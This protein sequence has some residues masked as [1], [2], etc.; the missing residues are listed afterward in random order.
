M[1][2]QSAKKNEQAIKNRV[3]FMNFIM[4]PLFAF[5]LL[6][7]MFF[8]IGE[9]I[10]F[11]HLIWCALISV[12]SFFCIKQTVKCWELNLPVEASEYYI[13]ILALNTIVAVLDPF[14]HKVW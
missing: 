11:W 14:T 6:L 2:N 1:A 3:K 13:D 10:S 4:Y 12:L 5:F 9:S 8:A 7:N